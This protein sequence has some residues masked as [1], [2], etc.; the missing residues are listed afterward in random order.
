MTVYFGDPGGTL[1]WMFVFWQVIAW[2]LGYKRIIRGLYGAHDNCPHPS[3]VSLSSWVS[4]S[5]WRDDAQDDASSLS[6]S[7]RSPSDWGDPS[8][9]ISEPQKCWRMGRGQCTHC[10]HVHTQCLAGQCDCPLWPW[11]MGLIS[12]LFPEPGPECQ[13]WNPFPLSK[14]GQASSISPPGKWSVGWSHLMRTMKHIFWNVCPNLC[15]NIKYIY[16]LHWTTSQ[17][18]GNQIMTRPGFD[19]VK[20]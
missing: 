9:S 18:N 1:W 16:Y 12:K 6:V 3:P 19:R 10:T 20:P 2:K 8:P 15:K 5:P 11:L 7:G 17:E 13:S 14:G 4:R